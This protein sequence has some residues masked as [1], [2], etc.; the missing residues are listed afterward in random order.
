[1][2]QSSSPG[3]GAAPTSKQLTARVIGISVSAAVGGFLFGFDS[4]VVNGAVDA[5]QDHFQLSEGLIGFAVASALLGCALGAY[6]AGRIADSRG[7]IFTMLLGAGLFFVSSFGAGFAFSPW[8]LILWRI[9]GGLGIGIAS[10][11]APAYIAEIA[12]SAIRGRLASL[13]QLAI[14][15]GIFAALLSDS[16]LA[17]VAGGA[18]N[19]LWFGV[20]AWR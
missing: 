1:M 14:T 5:M 11:V 2:S 4:S 12:P 18:S 6:L 8:D 9:V 3:T 16:V 15:L 19:P 17:G 13:Q 7:R 20:E 10:V